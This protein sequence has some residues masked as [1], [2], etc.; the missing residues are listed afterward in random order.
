VVLIADPAN[1]EGINSFREALSGGYSDEDAINE[2]L[3]NRAISDSRRDTLKKIA[4][5]F[6]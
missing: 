5:D 4:L 2:L 3:E 6:Q 1:E